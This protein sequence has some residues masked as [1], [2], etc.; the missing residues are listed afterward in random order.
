MAVDY[1][2][3]LKDLMNDFIVIGR[4]QKSAGTLEEKTGVKVCSGGLSQFIN[5]G[6]EIPEYAIVATS[7]ECLAQN[8]IELMD[9]GVK[10]IL[11]EK[12][13]G[14]NI[15]EIKSVC[16][17]SIATK[18]NVFIAYN[19]RF[20]SSVVEAKKLIK[21]DGGVTSFQF[22]FT[23]WSHEIEKLQKPAKVFQSWFLSNSSH[24]SDLAFFLGGKP[25][26][27]SCYVS[28]SLPWHSKGSVFS[29]AGIAQNGALFS[30]H[31]N[32]ESAGRWGVE[33]NTTKR[34]LIFRPLEKLQQQMRGT[35][36]ID[37]VEINDHLDIEYKPG[38]FLQTK[39]FLERQHHLLMPVKEQ[40]D[41]LPVYNRMLK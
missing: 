18:S 21:E 28:G 11:L 16:D 10:N 25:K 5:S 12:P 4:S 29:G 32:W 3:V 30:Y 13:G 34:K 38:L 26:E 41:I 14:L 33:I 27:I 1:V 7:I 24:V 36:K 22:D 9:F 15:E 17:K 39:A 31:A 35:V 8:A 20:Y 37:F 23:E 19:R 40:L 6:T 2:N